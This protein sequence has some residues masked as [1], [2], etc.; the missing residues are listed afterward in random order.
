M[1]RVT[2]DLWPQSSG[3]ASL[4]AEQIGGDGFSRE[5]R[6]FGHVHMNSGVLHSPFNA[7]SGVIRFAKGRDT[8][9]G[10]PVRGAFELSGD[11]GAAF[12]LRLGVNSLGYALI[13]DDGLNSPSTSLISIDAYTLETIVGAGGLVQN[14]EG[15]HNIIGASLSASYTDATISI[16]DDYTLVANTG[17]ITLRAGQAAMGGGA[18]TLRPFNSSGILDYRL[19]PHQSWYIKTSHSSTGGPLNDGYWPIAHSGNIGQMIT[20]A[21]SS[22]LQSAYSL[23]DEIILG[24][25]PALTP[26]GVLLKYPVGARTP[27]HNDINNIDP[28]YGIAVSGFS[29][30][31]TNISTYSLAILAPNALA[32][33]GSGQNSPNMWV[34]VD[35][36]MNIARIHTSGVLGISAVSGI[37]VTNRV[38]FAATDGTQ[39]P[40]NLSGM[41][42]PPTLT[43]L[44]VGDVFMMNHSVTSGIVGTTTD[45]VARAKALGVGG[46]AV[47]TNSGVIGLM[48]VSGIAQYL[49]IGTMQITTAV[50]NVPFAS[51]YQAADSNYTIGDEALGNSGILTVMSPGLYKVDVKVQAVKLVGTTPQSCRY[52]LLLNGATLLGDQ[53]NSFHFD[54]TNG[55]SQSASLTM[56]FNAEAGDTVSVDANST[57]AGSN[58]CSILNRGG[59]LVIQKIG[60]TRGQF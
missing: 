59:V 45:A 16:N 38:I 4:G 31:P 41:F 42:T 29:A 14:I 17:D 43:N 60:P 5:I 50:Q 15:I 20:Q 3:S 44:R 51:A 27:K 30:T 53:F 26:R 57:L 19:G 11:G 23:G 10:I 25:R 47:Q 58:N 13:A 33:R 37:L 18:V 40:L 8:A 56:I 32:I 35:N 9:V 48:T 52:R 36:A 54:T 22:G 12:P 55:Q 39:A 6:P 28:G 46:P 49:S 24:F 7:I 34:G 2:G 1:A 21:I